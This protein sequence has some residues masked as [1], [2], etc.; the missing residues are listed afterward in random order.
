MQALSRSAEIIGA[1]I[2]II[3][4]AHGIIDADSI[5]T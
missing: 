1:G 2:A 3:H 5:R 4:F